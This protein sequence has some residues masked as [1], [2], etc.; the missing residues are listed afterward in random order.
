MI[1]VHSEGQFLTVDRQRDQVQSQDARQQRYSPASRAKA[2]LL[3]L[4]PRSAMIASDDQTRKK[5]ENPCSNSDD[6][7]QKCGKK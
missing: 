1:E 7:V 5:K 2:R 4:H 6:R 3:P